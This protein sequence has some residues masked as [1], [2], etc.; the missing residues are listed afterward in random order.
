MIKYKEITQKPAGIHKESEPGWKTI[1]EEHATVSVDFKAG[2]PRAADVD[3][4]PD[5]WT[6]AI[7]S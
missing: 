2:G 6:N 4:Q 3:P 1:F 5:A 7:A